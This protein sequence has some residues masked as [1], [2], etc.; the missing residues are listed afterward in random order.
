MNYKQMTS[1]DIW[2]LFNSGKLDLDKLEKED[3]DTIFDIEMEELER[4]STHDMSLMEKCADILMHKYSDNVTAR[5]FTIDDI[6][7]IEK[8]VLSREQNIELNR[9]KSIPKRKMI[10]LIAAVLLVAAFSIVV[11]ANYD[12]LGEFGITIKDFFNMGGSVVTNDNSDL[13]IGDNMKYYNSYSELSHEI[14]FDI[15][16]PS[17]DFEYEIVK[18]YTAEMAGYNKIYIDVKVNDIII[19]Y[20]VYYGEQAHVIYG[21]ESTLAEHSVPSFECN[22]HKLYYVVTEDQYT[23]SLFDGELIYIFVSDTKEDIMEGVSMLD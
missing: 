6:A 23:A 1:K 16:Q 5:E 9:R 19:S 7:A 4:N 15:L 2:N 18:M 12:L 14:G 11:A 17:H 3:L 13:Y 22:G 8:E 21:S 20:N 10:V